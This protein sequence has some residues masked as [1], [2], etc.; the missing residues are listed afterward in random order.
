M[1]ISTPVA[2]LLLDLVSSF[3]ILPRKVVSVDGFADLGVQ[4]PF[5]MGCCCRLVVRAGD[6]F[7][8]DLLV[9]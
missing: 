8:L 4:S 2:I 3:T 7:V 9:R 5:L 6:G 1:G